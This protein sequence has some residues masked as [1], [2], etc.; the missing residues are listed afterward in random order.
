[1]VW[2]NKWDVFFDSAQKL[3]E[4]DPAHTRYVIKYRHKDGKLVL[5]VTDNRTCIKHKSSYE[6]SVKKMQQ[7]ND[8]L[9]RAMTEKK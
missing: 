9:L 2:L 8:L 6:S 3:Y 1:M 5:K 4:Q 7:L